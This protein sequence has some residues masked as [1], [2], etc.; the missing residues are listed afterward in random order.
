VTK[1]ENQI[2]DYLY[3]YGELSIQELSDLLGASEPSIRRDLVALNSNRFIERTRGGARL[4]MIVNP[5]NFLIY[6][7]PVN[8]KEALAIAYRAAQLVKPGSVVGIS[9]GRLCTQLSV[10]LRHHTNLTVVTNAVNIAVELAG[11]QEIQ[12]W[13]TGGQLNPGSFEL[14]GPSL[15]ASLIG[16]HIDQYFLGID[17]ISLEYGVT[18]HNEPEAA[19]ASSFMKI[20]DSTIVLADSLK[21]K[22]VS[23]S[24]VASISAIDAIVTT[25]AAP[26]DILDQIQASGV[27]IIIA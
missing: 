20:A 22:K 5:E 16:L 17:G 8:P 21:F 10:N 3:Q 18:G 14:V 15:N 4:A 7:L 6:R 12:V 25:E 2:L 1:R 23:F 19:A 9:G 24:Q 27:K 11:L 13:L 26:R